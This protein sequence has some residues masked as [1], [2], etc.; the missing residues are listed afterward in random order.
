MF[1][2]NVDNKS[3]LSSIVIL[4]LVT[5]NTYVICTTGSTFVVNYTLVQTQY[6][7]IVNAKILIL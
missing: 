5:I 3:I 2:L 1:D 6:Y 4:L 7:N